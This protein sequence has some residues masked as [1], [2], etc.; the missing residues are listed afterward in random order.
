MT[1]PIKPVALIVAMPLEFDAVCAMMQ[2]V[3]ITKRWDLKI[4]EGTVDSRPVAMTLAG[5]GKANAAYAAGILI[6]A[7]CPELVINTGIAGGLGVTDKL[8]VVVATGVVQHD[9]DTS[10]LGD[11]VGWIS[12]VDRILI[13]TDPERS[14]TLA[15]AIGAKRGIVASGDVFVAS[16]LTAHTIVDRFGAVACDMECAAVG[17]AAYRAKIPFVA[18]KVISDDGKDGSELTFE[19]FA[20]IAAERNAAAFRTI[21][22][23]LV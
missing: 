11:P 12:G 16:D 17:L 13:E 6:A 22:K 5:V 20:A 21:V 23:Y 2:D 3:R 15:E 10:A 18:V 7:F 9:M 8:D 14:A 1:K 19:Q 4:A